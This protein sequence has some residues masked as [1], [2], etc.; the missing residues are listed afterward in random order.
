MRICQLFLLE[1]DCCWQGFD[2]DMG[3]EIEL[4][5][6]IWNGDLLGGFVLFWHVE[7]WPSSQPAGHQ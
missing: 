2:H 7:E 4:E 3:F 1:N 5:I 6:W